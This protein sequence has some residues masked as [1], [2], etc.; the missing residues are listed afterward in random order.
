MAGM[1][2]ANDV[3]NL[4]QCL[5]IAGAAWG[6]DPENY[7]LWGAL[8]LT[9]CMW[10]WRRLVLD[11]NRTSGLRRV[12]LSPAQFKKCMMRVSASED[13]VDWLQRR[14]LS[15]RDRA[16]CFRR[17]CGLFVASLKQEGVEKPAMPKPAWVA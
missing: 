3:A 12:A 13:Y 10:L 5:Q 15:D 16:P 8:N 14:L 11:Q 7:R 2:E 4:V 6:R 1:L 17:L 9:M